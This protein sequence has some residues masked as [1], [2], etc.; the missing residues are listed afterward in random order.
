[1]D[2]L[3]DHHRLNVAVSR[4]K[5]IAI[6]VASPEL[7]RVR[8]RTP[9]QMRRANA[10]CR[11]VEVAAEQGGATEAVAAVTSGAPATASP[12]PLQTSLWDLGARS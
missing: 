7:L 5:A 8:P 6:V 3:Y 1:M 4:A 9:G 12:A 11:L 2:F 10:L